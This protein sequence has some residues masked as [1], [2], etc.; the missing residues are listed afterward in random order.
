MRSSAGLG[1]KTVWSSETRS[2]ARRRRRWESARRA[3]V[4]EG[5]ETQLFRRATDGRLAQ[6]RRHRRAALKLPRTLGVRE[7]RTWSRVGAY[8]LVARPVFK[9][10]EAVAR[11]LVG[12]IP[13]R[14]RQARQ[15]AQVTR[16]RMSIC[17]PLASRGVS[18]RRRGFVGH[19]SR[20][21]T[22]CV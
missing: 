3:P 12:S 9:T 11:R 22:N 16:M 19:G 20:T 18:C 2:R 6:A 7:K 10:G 14:S 5:S 8:G 1:P 15:Y 17:T 21:V 4:E 13:T